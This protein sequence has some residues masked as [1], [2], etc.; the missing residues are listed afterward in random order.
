MKETGSGWAGGKGLAASSPGYYEQQGK[1]Y[2]G[3]RHTYN[4]LLQ[5]LSI[6][7]L[8]CLA[9]SGLGQISTDG[10]SPQTHWNSTLLNGDDY[11]KGISPRTGRPTAGPTSL[12][13]SGC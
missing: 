11:P 12:P 4:V 10:R 6:R 1:S 8:S 7:S 13:L 9:F 2:R 5:M 3:T